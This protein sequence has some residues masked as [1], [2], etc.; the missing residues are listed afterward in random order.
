[1]PEAAIRSDTRG[2]RTRETMLNASGT[3]DVRDAVICT[4]A[5][6]VDRALFLARHAGID[7][8][9]VGLPSTVSRSARGLGLEAVKTTL[10]FLE[11]YLR[12][13]PR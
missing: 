11:S 1:M 8:V 12:R 2:F 6:Y 3:F 13:G 7:A 4:Q 10:A 5:P 9:A